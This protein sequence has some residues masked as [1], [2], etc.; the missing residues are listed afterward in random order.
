MT[1][2]TLYRMLTDSFST[3]IM[4]TVD[5][6]TP[7]GVKAK[8]LLDSLS[9]CAEFSERKK[10]KKKNFRKEPEKKLSKS[11]RKLKKLK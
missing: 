9:S 8:L 5:K 10:E 1:D 2:K 11:I 6:D 7:W 3:T 4:E